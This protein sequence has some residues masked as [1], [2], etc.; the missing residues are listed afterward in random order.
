[1]KKT[2]PV[3]LANGSK[4]GT[5]FIGGTHHRVRQKLYVFVTGGHDRL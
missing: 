2:A 4:P 3:E 1:M 5:L